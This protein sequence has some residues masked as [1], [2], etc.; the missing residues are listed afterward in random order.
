MHADDRDVVLEH[1]AAVDAVRPS[2]GST[3]SAAPRGAAQSIAFCKLV[4][5]SAGEFV[6]RTPKSRMLLYGG[7]D[8]S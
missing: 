6:G 8:G 4:L 3:N 2:D 5:L 7:D 1:E